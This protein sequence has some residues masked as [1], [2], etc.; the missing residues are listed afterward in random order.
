MSLN[1]F[2]AGMLKM[3]LIFGVKRSAGIVPVISLTSWRPRADKPV[4]LVGTEELLLHG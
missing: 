2:S 4:S 1:A 3:F